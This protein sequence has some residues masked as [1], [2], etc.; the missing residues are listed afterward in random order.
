MSAEDAAIEA[1]WAPDD[2]EGRRNGDRLYV[3]AG[4]RLGVYDL[5]TRELLEEL[6]LAASAVAVDG[7]DHLLYAADP[8]GRL[9][10]FDTTWFDA[11]RF[12]ADADPAAIVDAAIPFSF[13]PGAPVQ[14]LLVT[15]T[16]LV[17]VTLGSIAS[18]DTDTGELLSERLA[19]GIEDVVE[20]PW[21]ERLIVD[22][23]ALPDRK[24][25]ADLL[26]SV[27]DDDPGRLTELLARDGYVTILAWPDTDTVEGLSAFIE[28]GR[29]PGAELE[30]APL[31]AVA[32]AAGVDILD[33][34]SLDPLDTI[35]TDEPARALALAEP[36]SDE[37][38]LY[39]AAGTA[40]E[41]I[42]VSD[43][44]LALPESVWMP[45]VVE[46]LVWNGSAELMHALGVAP[47]GGPTVYVVEP[48]GRSVF[49]DVPLP[50]Q[51]RIL[52]AD[53]VSERPDAD[54]SELL[55][56][57]ADGRV[58]GIDIGGNAFGW[59]APGVLLGALTA[60]LAYLLA[61]VLFA[62]RSVGLITAALVLAEGMLFANARIAMN[63][64]YVTAFV[65]LAVLLLAPLYLAPRRPWTAAGLVAGAGVALGL[66]LASKWVA[67][68]AIGGLGLLVLLRSALG[69]A[70][71]LL[72]MV[73]MTAVLGTMAIRPE[74]G[75]EVVR[76]WVFLV[77]MLVLTGLLAA[78][79]IRRPIPWTKVEVILAVALPLAAGVALWLLQLSVLGGLSM[80]VGVVVAVMA[81]IA[82]MAGHG[83][84]A[85]G[86]RGPVPGTSA[87][88]RPG[89]VHVL[90]WLLTM[91]A[92]TVLPVIVYLVTYSP[93]VELGNDWGVPLLG[94]L[95]FLAEGTEG[96]RTIAALT[97][98]MYQYH[99]NLRAEHAASSPWWAWPLD[100]KPVWFFQGRYSDG[101]TGL[102]Y[103]TGNLVIFW[104]GIA[105][106]GFSAW[107]AWRRRSLALTMVVLMWAAMWLPWARVDR[108]AF[109]YHV[110][111][112]LP[113]M[114]LALAYF[115][116]ELW[117]GPS[118]RVW[119]LARASAAAAIVAIPLLWLLRTPLC[120]ISGTAVA[121]P[122]GVACASQVTRT[123]QLSEGGVAALFVVGAGAAM[124]GLLGW[125]ASRADPGRQGRWVVALV[126][127]ALA[128][129]TGVI[130]AL[131][132][133]DT[134][135][136][137]G[138]TLSSDVLALL[139]LIVLAL[140]AA[141]VLRARD[142]RRLVVGILAAAGIWLLLWYPNIAGLPLPAD[143][144]HLYQGLL[145][146]W[147]WDFQFSVNTDPASDDGIFE[148]AMLVL[149][150]VTVLFVLAVA[151]AARRWGADA[152]HTSGP[153]G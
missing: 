79:I 53:S 141:A 105:G 5:A 146:T 108:A 120:I 134:A 57:A 149:G 22:T 48:K 131:L 153:R 130:G 68:Y 97:E 81:L 30:S 82:A 133:L 103:D 114:L 76:N 24:A 115:L 52:L 95:P 37:P 140:P 83:P 71:A 11:Q 112:S 117:H 151:V 54:R 118:W 27:L 7:D 34:W 91:A 69:R 78:G 65:L 8:A 136:T 88:L 16:A 41:T 9:Y 102:I 101:T 73:G 33:V 63:D 98:S 49:I 96:G 61:R 35:P 47:S 39:V 38:T 70:L 43:D 110:Y 26:A 46:D 32:D 124:A 75:S 60:A 58:A 10:R 74:A 12:G 17:A 21:A 6:P 19:V 100:L 139:G 2:D 67:L 138:V 62:R 18:F 44:G 28:D 3:A 137:A 94:S 148:P 1:R 99:D 4:D 45:G 72:V 132:A 127:V 59:R 66:A 121:H 92:L 15:D 144:A 56:I 129:L 20:L 85:V 31:L 147:N 23:R 142:P 109:Q 126:A 122:E 64:V 106:I 84:W 93:W 80:V 40:L 152:G 77:L 128:T 135:S 42:S 86:A 119:F 116:G 125:R 89:P 55:A 90:P 50:H 51:P 111:A 13:G 29:L 87:W 123:A 145:P 143:L 25:T 113:F 14:R 104:L 150:G 36:D 107:A